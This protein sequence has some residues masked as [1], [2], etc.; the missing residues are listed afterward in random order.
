LSRKWIAA[1]CTGVMLALTLSSI[2][3]PASAQAP[4]PGGPS[5]TRWNGRTLLPGERIVHT[6]NGQQAVVMERGL[7][8]A[9]DTAPLVVATSGGPDIFGYT[10]ASSALGSKW[11][12][13]TSGTNT[14]LS[15]GT[16]GAAVTADPIDLGFNFDFYGNSYSNV[17]VSTAGAIGFSPD[18]LKNK[19][20]LIR[21]PDYS[22]P[23]NVI[24]PY[25]APFLVNSGT[26]TGKI[27]TLTGTT[28]PGNV[29]YFAVEWQGVRDNLGGVYTFETVLYENGDIAF[30]Y[31]SMVNNG[32]YYGG[33][34]AAIENANGDDGLSYRDPAGDNDMSADTGKSVY[35]T[36]PAPKPPHAGIDIYPLYQG[37]LTA[38]GKEKRF[39]VTIHNSGTL[40]TDDTYDISVSS[41]WTVTLYK[42]DG[43]TLL[44]NTGGDSAVDTGTVSSGDTVDIIA[45]VQTPPGALVGANNTATLAIQSSLGDKPMLTVRLQLAV[46]VPFAQAYGSG[47]FYGLTLAQ[48][49]AQAAKLYETVQGWPAPTMVEL[50]NGNFLLLSRM[51][52]YNGTNWYDVMEYF[53]LDHAGQIVRP[54]SLLTLPASDGTS[55][56][57][58]APSAA[59]AADGKIG[60]VWSFTNLKKKD[61]QNDN[62]TYPCLQKQDLYFAV[63]TSAGDV[64]YAP[65]NLTKNSVWGNRCDYDAVPKSHAYSEYRVVA[66]DDNRFVLS[67][68][69]NNQESTW[70]EN[71]SDNYFMVRKS[72][73]TLRKAATPLTKDVV[74]GTDSFY[75]PTL[76]KLPNH[77]VLIAWILSSKNMQYSIINSSDANSTPVDLAVGLDTL[78]G[79]VKFS[80]GN[81]LLLG[82]DYSNLQYSI[83]KPAAAT[84]S[85]PAP[86]TTTARYTLLSGPAPLV[87]GAVN[88]PIAPSAI[89][90]ALGHAVVTWGNDGSSILVYALIDSNGGLT[91]PPQVLRSGYG[92]SELGDVGQG[93]TTYSWQP[94][95]AKQDVWTHVPAVNLL[96]PG[97]TNTIPITFGNLSQLTATSVKLTVTL[98]S[99]LTYIPGSCFQDNFPPIDPVVTYPSG[100]TQLEFSFGPLNFLDNFSCDPYVSIP[101]ETLGTTHTVDVEITAAETD[102]VLTNN[103]VHSSVIAAARTFLPAINK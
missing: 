50:P 28:T 71:L 23:N 101:S 44:T 102:A 25:M 89:A 52:R 27:Y 15:Q 4:Q 26:Y 96:P 54:Y 103:L 97:I 13:A 59:V 79:G 34:G 90:D 39:T 20:F 94:E 55:Y 72:D 40:S 43:T 80:D 74:G 7:L 70:K 37:Q 56:D 48:T 86:G 31:Q 69:D 60:L 9:Q 18:S 62:E 10:W 38:A 73:G 75:N 51:D 91:T 53:I 16:W 66:T 12:D 5:D 63:L 32:H 29:D 45:A 98:G 85:Y 100:K 82:G 83:L 19:N 61:P 87:S 92:G 81:I 11:I 3:V 95:T 84:S 6:Q 36:H 76:V 68:N 21:I 33:T 22:D 49:G 93:L 64:A 35:F 1:L 2:M 58:S 47:D 65:E 78:T 67:W 41:P 99:G 42:A 46:P 30:N 24:A 77:E 88:S 14:D 17:Y 8:A 57:L